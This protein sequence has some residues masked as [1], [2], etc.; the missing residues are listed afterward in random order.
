MNTGYSGYSTADLHRSNAPGVGTSQY[1]PAAAAARPAPP[2][3]QP[4]PT[5]PVSPT[6]SEPSSRATARTI[7]PERKLFLEN[8]HDEDEDGD[9]DDLASSSA[10]PAAAGGPDDLVGDETATLAE[11]PY[12][13]YNHGT[14]T[15]EDDKT[16]IQARTRGQNW[17]ELQRA[18]FPGKTAN[19]CRKRYE[20]LVERRGIYDYSGRRLEIIANEYMGMR[21][22]IWSGLADRVGMKW[23][24]VEALCMGVGLRTI[25]SNAR[26]YTNRARRESKLEQKTRESQAEAVSIASMGP[27]PLAHLPRPLPM[28]AEQGTTFTDRGA[29]AGGWRSDASLMPPPPTCG[30]PGGPGPLPG[31]R[32]PPITLTPLENLG[33]Y[34]NG[35]FG[36]RGA[37]S[38]PAGPQQQQPPPSGM[39][40]DW[41]PAN[42]RGPE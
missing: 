19:A 8:H 35:G 30:P 21:R 4:P 15:A 25:Q 41:G 24:V 18:H 10:P 27:P 40:P 14:W 28:A 34:G 36:A 31:G 13:I 2:T 26:S 20:R 42:V 11:Y 23:E 22:D 37:F 33:G 38:H 5:A 7:V 39:V 9:D 16:L 12:S 1:P 6:T 32:L 3:P 29:L 17:A